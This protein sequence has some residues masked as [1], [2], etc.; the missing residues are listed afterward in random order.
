NPVAYFQKMLYHSSWPLSFPFV[1]VVANILDFSMAFFYPILRTLLYT[2]EFN[3]NP[4]NTAA[5]DYSV[6]R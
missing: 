1:S 3:K 4:L 6:Q 5:Y 2:I